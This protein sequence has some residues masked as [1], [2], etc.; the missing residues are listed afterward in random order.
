MIFNYRN[1]FLSCA[2]ISCALLVASTTAQANDSS[3]DDQWIA[4]CL[5][6]H[7]PG[8][9]VD[10][11]LDMGGIWQA[12]E[13][14]VKGFKILSPELSRKLELTPAPT[15]QPIPLLIGHYWRCG[16]DDD[17]FDEDGGFEFCEPV[18]VICTDDQSWCVES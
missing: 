4:H 8:P 5:T 6:E 18:L 14:R 1:S 10:G 9:D 13:N 11:C 3:A 7:E 2:V 12:R 15:S 17:F 16:I